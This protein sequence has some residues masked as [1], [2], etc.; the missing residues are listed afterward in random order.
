MGVVKRER[1]M[2]EIE[3]RPSITGRLHVTMFSVH[4][5]RPW[6]IGLGN[7]VDQ[8]KTFGLLVR[9]RPEE[10]K[11]TLLFPSGGKYCNGTSY[12]PAV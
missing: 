5:D 3:D 12:R 2:T 11:L 9:S 6:L 10:Q 4:S 1:G 8:A 7:R